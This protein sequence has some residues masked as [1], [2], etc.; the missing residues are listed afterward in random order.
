GNS[1][2]TASA[3]S[4][5]LLWST[6]ET[7]NSITVTTAGT[8]SVTQTVGSCT[9]ISTIVIASPMLVPDAPLLSVTNNCGNSVL[10]AS[11]NIG[12]LTWSNG[13]TTNMITVVTPG[14]Y[15]VIQTVGTCVSAP[16][17]GIAAPML[18]PTTPVVTVTNNCGNAVL[19]ASV[20]TGSLL[21]STSETSPSITVTNVGVY[22]VTQTIG[23]CTSADGIGLAGPF[24]IPPAPI[25]SVTNNCGNSVL[26]ASNYIGTLLW[27]TSE[28][29]PS[30]TV[31]TAGVYTVTQTVGS[32]TSIT[33]IGVATP[34]VIP[35]APTVTVSNNCGNSVLTASNTIG[36]LTWSNGASTNSI[37]VTIPGTYSVTQTVGSCISV[38]TSG[39][40]APLTQ[41]LAPVIT[42][43]NN[44]GNSLLT[45]SNYTGTLMWNTSETTPSI[46]VLTGGTYSVTQTLG[47]CT[48]AAA[49]AYAMPYVIPTAP[50]VTVINNC[51]NSVLTAFIYTGNLLWSTSE[52]TQSI[53]VTTAGTYSVTQTVGICTG[54]ATSVVAAPMYVPNAPTV[55][56]A[57]NCGNS[58]LTASDYT[59]TLLWS[60]SETTPSITVTESGTYT[61]T[62][63]VGSCTGPEGSGIAAPLPIPSTPVVTVTDNCGNSVLT[64][65][66]YT[67][68][69]LWSTGETT[70]S[71]TVT[72]AG[73][74]TVTQT[75][76]ICAS[77]EA[78]G[79]AAPMIQPNIPIVSV[80]NNCGNSVLTVT[81]IEGT[82][83]WSTGSTT[84]SIHVPVA[85]TY[86]VTQTIGSCTSGIGSIFASPLIVPDAPIVTVINNCGNSTLSTLASGSLAWSTGETTSS[87]TVTL[88]GTYT[89]TQSDGICTS[90]EGSG[91]AAPISVPNAPIL[92]V[93]NNCGN[94][95]I[96]ALAYSGTL[97]WSTGETTSSITVLTA[98]TYSVTQTVAGCTS[99]EG[100]I[101]AAPKLIPDAPIV[102][103]SDNCGNS[104]LTASG[105]LGTLLW[106]TGETTNS[107][108]VTSSGMYSVTQTVDGCISTAGTGT[109]APKII[110]SAPSVS[111]ANNCSNSVL[112]ASAYT[113]TLLWSTTE[114]TSS[115]TVVTAGIYSVTQT[116]DG[117]TGPAGN[118][119]A[120]PLVIPSAPIITVVNN[121]G[122]SVLTASSYSGTLLWSTTATTSSITVA[123]PGIYTVTQ[124][125]AG[126]IS[127]AGSG[128]AAP[129]TIPSAPVVAVVNNCG[130][131]VLTASAYS[132]TLLWSNA[133]TTSS[134]TVA[135]AGVFTVTQT[136]SGCIS[137]VGSGTAA[138]LTI[139]TAPV[140]GVV[141]NCG[142]SVLTASAYTGALTWNTGATT[143]SITATTAGVYSVVQTISGCTS[144]AGSGT[145]APLTIP[146]APSV[147]VINNCGNSLLTVSSYTGSLLWNTGLTTTSI[148]VTTPGTYTVT[149]TVGTCTSP[150]ASGVAAPM[151]IPVAPIVTVTNYC[152]ISVLSTTGTS[153]LW[154]TGA[155]SNSITVTT[156]GTYTVTQTLGNCTSIAGSGIATPNPI[157][158][159]P[160][161]NVTNNCGNSVLTASAYSGTLTWSTG[162]TVNS[163][164]VAL[165]GA[166]TVTQTVGSC[167]SITGTGIALPLTIP[168]TPV[169]TVINNCG[170]SLL[171]ASP[172]TGT[173]A[174]N[175][176]AT[177]SSITV[178]MPG[179][180]SV[181]QTVGSCTS[182]SASGIAAPF[183]APAA[184]VVM[185]T[186]NCGNSVITASSYSGSLAWNTGATSGSI[187]VT[188]PGTYSVTQ[189]VGSCT[190]NS[191][192]ATAAPKTI[193]IVNLGSDTILC[194]S[195]SFMLDAGNSGATYQWTPLGQTSQSITVDTLGLGTGT[196]II[197]V[198]VTAANSCTASDD[199]M[200]TFNPCAGITENEDDISI[201]VVPN[202]SNGVFY[203]SVT[204]LNEVSTLNIFSVS[205]QII[206]KE[207]ID[208]AGFVNK[209]IDLSS[210]PTGMYFIRIVSKN[211]SHVEKIILE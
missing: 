152:G 154:N 1:V 117:C 109:A 51:G 33:G 30:I 10:V 188:A 194:A 127:S 141:N 71:I 132:G 123:T 57:D 35:N 101:L 165:P 31:T 122:N 139:P 137:A 110:P 55:T 169:V 108:T 16:A 151:T 120:A 40:A 39:I 86:T 27:N 26:T 202:P 186:N 15:T 5:T 60:T 12:P 162:A 156:P 106:N 68:T 78:T 124:T 185:V 180:Y 209:P 11:N 116:V 34:L 38:S 177:T 160:V 104:V 148:T 58:V 187:T 66:D 90:I 23:S 81:N 89:V 175:T 29:T 181:T 204:G 206:Y 170:N 131:S 79:I 59:G 37:T 22:T 56:V 197:S 107:I 147:N 61:V 189:T 91:I 88:P 87:I 96:N 72:E 196:H 83:L 24:A 28:T 164:T 52:T 190:S 200:V 168:T 46:T 172:Y 155:A 205:G 146:L 54:P 136:V 125:V 184:P 129:I 130:N 62:Q 210:Y 199:V 4:G 171:A 80:T 97:V 19:T 41:P 198:L 119:T 192:L 42:V 149:Q 128:T 14:T 143:S 73:T 43:T 95:V 118:G 9:S 173:L 105:Y 63:T 178:T 207:Q 135:T 115:I 7:T 163:I 161:V 75:V 121:C 112:T 145:A 153:L 144:P 176:G 99:L 36:I 167:T 47:T 49:S 32:C 65:S 158:T 182:A 94:S 166:Y 6:T 159:A 84:N 208:N 70:P 133:A 98:G 67:G 113:G 193:P 201:S 44:C 45:A 183:T 138:P 18:V 82:L 114:T 48:S 77:L 203:L 76:G 53:T 92:T 13:A 20:Y 191:A 17:S 195:Q 2:L 179:T 126:C 142:T 8:Y 150:S 102:S 3:Y 64:A 111:V 93:V 174:W 25:V 74:Y 85:G 157:P 21:W 69:L 100:S 50:V 134:I 211:Y 140:V 103:V